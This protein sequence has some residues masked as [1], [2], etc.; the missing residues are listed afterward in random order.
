[1]LCHLKCRV[2][3]VVAQMSLQLQIIYQKQ[4]KGQPHKALPLRLQKLR[5]Q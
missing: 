3:G 2:H 4:D 1:M 5:Q